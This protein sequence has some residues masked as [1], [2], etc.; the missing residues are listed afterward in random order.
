M[1]GAF[2]G[3]APF[4]L[5]ASDVSDALLEGSDTLE[6]LRSVFFFWVTCGLQP[7]K[8][9]VIVSPIVSVIPRVFIL[10]FL[11]SAKN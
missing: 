11:R 3:K 5:T 6:S 4:R 10:P 7:N 1:E 2:F 9:K 8:T